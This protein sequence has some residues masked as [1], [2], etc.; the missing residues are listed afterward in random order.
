M[1]RFLAITLALLTLVRWALG[2][3]L[4]IT[5]HEAYLYE[6][7]KHSTW[8][9]CD[10]GG[11]PAMLASGVRWQ[12][13]SAFAL[14][15][16]APLGAA[17]G[18]ILLFL[19]I[20]QLA[21]ERTAAWSVVILN[22]LPG[23]NLGAVLLQPAWIGAY[24]A[25][26]GIKLLWTGMH[27]AN[28][29]DW[30]WPVAGLL[31]G[32]ALLSHWGALMLPC[33]L[34]FL[35][36]ASRRWRKR[37]LRPG[38]WLL[39]LVWFLVGLLPLILW[40][41]DHGGAMV[42]L[43]LQEMGWSEVT[44]FGWNS[45]YGVAIQSLVAFSPLMLVAAGIALARIIKL[46][47]RE[48]ASFFLLAFTLPTFAIVLILSIFGLGK[49]TL[50]IPTIP[51]LCGLLSM[52]WQPRSALRDRQSLWQWIA[53]GTSA[54]ISLIVLHTD[55]LRRAHLVR[56]YTWDATRNWQGWQDTA[57]EAARIVRDLNQSSP[58]PVFLIA[59]SPTLAA[60][61]DY[62]LPADLTLL[63]PRPEWPRVQVLESPVPTS[64]YSFWPRYDEDSSLEGDDPISAPVLG[65]T[66]L[67]FTDVTN[68]IG[69]PSIIEAS[70]R[71]V[72]PLMVYE[73]RRHGAIVR[74]IKVFACQDYRGT[75]L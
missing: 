52:V 58:D 75:P 20:Q 41:H 34:I 46:R 70:F 24:F 59:E 64:Q 26:G 48:D 28:K 51:P 60:A 53:I 44:W 23:F 31:W 15:F 27:R 16:A 4:E 73:I 66:A 68:R 74:R 39:L 29:W 47:P 6:L 57:M 50:L 2:S 45:I 37:V 17:I 42:D 62:Y 5:P 9:G 7:A 8:V 25:L 1:L 3:I 13:N 69:P 18:S 38:P 63:S 10:G 36:G 11:I 54:I 21:T 71:E 67:F 43:L 32:L 65:K 72:S 33:S 12:E 30:R 14:R 56:E 40:D 49:S 35:F 19:L 61:L 22:I 55:L